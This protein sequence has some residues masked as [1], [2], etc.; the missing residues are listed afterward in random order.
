[1]SKE[2]CFY[3]GAELIGHAELKRKFGRLSRNYPYKRTG[4]HKLPR[5]RGGTDDPENLVAG[6]SML[7]RPEAAPESAPLPRMASTPTSVS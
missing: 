1:M 7:Q 2:C 4:D 5:S 6:M 3:C